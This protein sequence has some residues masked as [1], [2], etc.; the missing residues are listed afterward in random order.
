MAVTADTYSAP[1]PS[2]ASVSADKPIAHDLDEHFLYSLKDFQ[3]FQSKNYQGVCVCVC[4][5]VYYGGGM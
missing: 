1:P 3:P 5:C 4:V 2:S